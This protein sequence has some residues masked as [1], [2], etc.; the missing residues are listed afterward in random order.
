MRS[1]LISALLFV[2][3]GNAL[4]DTCIWQ[5]VPWMSVSA[6]GEWK[7]WV[8]PVETKKEHYSWAA[9]YRKGRK[10]ARWR[11][12]NEYSPGYALVSNDG[13]TVTF[14]NICRRGGG[15]HVVVIYRPDGK[16]VRTQALADFLVERDVEALSRSVSSIH[17]SGTHRIDEE[18]RQLILQVNGPPRMVELPIDLETGELLVPKTTRF[19]SSWFPTPTPVVTYQTDPLDDPKARRCDGGIAVSSADFLAHATT[20]VAAPYPQVAMKARIQGDVV[21]D[22]VVSENGVVQGVAI[23]KPLPFGLDTAAFEAAEK[24]RFRPLE[25]D[26]KPVKMC[27]RFTMHFALTPASPP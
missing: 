23:V 5:N 3:C 2:L 4:A 18:K 9:L 20:A 10:K 1:F 24:W 11:L 14:D 8:V 6:N 25:Q 17:W 12:V 16:L 21:L 19:H 22:V 15:E 7:L 13:T 27:G 26:G